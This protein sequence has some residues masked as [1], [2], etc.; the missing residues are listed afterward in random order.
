MSAPEPT[1]GYVALAQSLIRLKG[2]LEESQERYGFKPT[3]DSPAVREAVAPGP[4][5]GASVLNAY[6]DTNILVASASDHLASLA[7]V[8]ASE[9]GV[10]GC[11]T[12]ARATLEPTGRVAYLLE[13]GIG[14]EER[15]RRATNEVL[16]SQHERIQLAEGLG[17]DASQPRQYVDAVL[18]RAAAHGLLVKRS[19][20]HR[21]AHVG[22]PRPSAMRVLDDLY[23]LVPEA[24]AGAGQSLYRLLCSVAHSSEHGLAQLVVPLEHSGGSGVTAVRIG[25]DS[26]STAGALL[27]VPNFYIEAAMRVHKQLGWDGRPFLSVAV[28]AL[29]LWR[30]HAE[31]T[32]S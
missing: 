13:E 9:Y 31:T 5:Q 27:A 21:P 29:R 15:V 16:W 17:M 25:A 24:R 20:N 8:L 22:A 1:S 12:L 18:A 2:A 7:V 23:A 28:A 10:Y 11:Y 3:S 26:A 30:E 19:K 6:T 4:W 32:A 14:P